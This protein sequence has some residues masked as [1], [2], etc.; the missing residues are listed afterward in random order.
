MRV[1][2]F[3]YVHLRTC[4]PCQRTRQDFVQ[5][6]EPGKDGKVKSRQAR[7]T[8]RLY[9]PWQGTQQDVVIFGGAA[10]LLASKL[11]DI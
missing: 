11:T 6:T 2:D 7:T 4:R 8:T 9:T 1:F 5:T 10:S 3:V